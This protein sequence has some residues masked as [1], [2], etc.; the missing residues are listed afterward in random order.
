MSWK[1]EEK[2]LRWHLNY[3]DSVITYEDHKGIHTYHTCPFCK[4][5][6]TRSGKCSAC[7]RKEKAAILDAVKAQGSDLL[8]S[9]T[10]KTWAAFHRVLG[11]ETGEDPC[12]KTNGKQS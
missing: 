6:S 3:L 4:K 7:L 9:S 10:E 2:T 11:I 12:D 5:N 1:D 8:T